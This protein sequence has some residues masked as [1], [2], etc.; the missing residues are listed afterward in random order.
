M[1]KKRVLEMLR[2]SVALKEIHEVRIDGYLYAQVQ[3]RREGEFSK[4]TNPRLDRRFIQARFVYLTDEA[5]RKVYKHRFSLFSS[6]LY[7]RQI[8]TSKSS[9]NQEWKLNDYVDSVE[10]KAPGWQ[11]N[12]TP[13]RFEE[14]NKNIVN[15]I[16][17]A[18]LNSSSLW[19]KTISCISSCPCYNY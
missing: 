2:P 4:D 8:D 11:F 6:L 12:L 16:I 9:G 14:E 1:T 3:Q 15:G 17:K 5:I 13:L 18:L 19:V 7:N 10:E